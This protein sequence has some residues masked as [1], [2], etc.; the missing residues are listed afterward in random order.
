[1]A[2]RRGKNVGSDNRIRSSGAILPFYRGRRYRNCKDLDTLRDF[3]QENGK[4]IPARLT[5]TKAHFQR[6]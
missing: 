4:I 6:H 5:G 3:V 2:Y 1:M